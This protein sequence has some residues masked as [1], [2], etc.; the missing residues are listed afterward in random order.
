MNARL[1]LRMLYDDLHGAARAGIV[2][3]GSASGAVPVDAGDVDAY[4]LGEPLP[5]QVAKRPTVAKL[6]AIGARL[7]GV[8]GARTSGGVVAR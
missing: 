8:R 3:L 7:A 6:D 5:S 1:A 2:M 4:L